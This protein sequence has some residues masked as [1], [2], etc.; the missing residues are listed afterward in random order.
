MCGW[1][2]TKWRGC[3]YLDGATGHALCTSADCWGS[4]SDICGG[5][6]EK[7]TTFYFYFYK[8]PVQNTLLSRVT[9]FFSHWNSICKYIHLAHNNVSCSAMF[10]V[11]SKL[12][13]IYNFCLPAREILLFWNHIQAELGSNCLNLIFFLK[14]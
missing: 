9:F 6:F 14:T 4:H 12:S 1:W 5:L 11:T 10:L 8:D 3:C 13:Y 7:V 2:R